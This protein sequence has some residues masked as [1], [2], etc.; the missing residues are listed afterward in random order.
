M[1]DVA[2]DDV[3]LSPECF[4]VNIPP[5]EL[6][7]YNYWNPQECDADKKEM[8]KDFVNKTCENKY[9]SMSE[10]LG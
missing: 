4:G 10:F 9:Y 3:S 1:S 2:I 7:C 5:E 8:H 6:Q